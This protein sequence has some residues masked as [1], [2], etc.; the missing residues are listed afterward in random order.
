MGDSIRL[1]VVIEQGASEATG[2]IQRS[3]TER[4]SSSPTVQ[5]DSVPVRCH[6][7]QSLTADVASLRAWNGPFIY[8]HYGLAR[9]VSMSSK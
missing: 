2:L 3:S 9:C 4:C 1:A 8:I 7:V 5:P 6:S